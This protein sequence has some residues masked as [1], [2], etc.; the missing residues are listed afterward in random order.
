MTIFSNWLVYL[1]HP[2]TNHPIVKTG[3]NLSIKSF[4]ITRVPDI[5]KIL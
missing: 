1:L 5:Q 2:T 3:I 4:Q